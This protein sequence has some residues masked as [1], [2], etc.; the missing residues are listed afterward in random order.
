MDFLT[1]IHSTKSLVPWNLP[2]FSLSLPFSLSLSLS[3]SFSLSLSL[4]LSLS[5]PFPS[6]LSSFLPQKQ[7]SENTKKHKTKPR[8]GSKSSRVDLTI[9]QQTWMSSLTTSFPSLAGKCLAEEVSVFFL[10]V[11]VLL[12]IFFV[13]SSVI[14]YSRINSQRAHFKQRKGSQRNRGWG[15]RVD[16]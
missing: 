7:Q 8:G 9:R 10:L 4:S 15:S 5:P 12:F 6:F 1:K 16:K 3:L 14:G 11:C 13:S 2:W